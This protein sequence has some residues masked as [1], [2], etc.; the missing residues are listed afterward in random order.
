MRLNRIHF[1]LAA[2]VL[3]GHAQRTARAEV[4]SNWQYY[5]QQRQAEVL[6]R[7]NLE[8]AGLLQIQQEGLSMAA[9]YAAR[10][11]QEAAEHSRQLQV[12]VAQQDQRIA[13]LENQLSE[14]RQAAAEAEEA[15]IEAAREEARRR[16]FAQQWAAAAPARARAA[17]AQKIA[18]EKW[19]ASIKHT[20]NIMIGKNA[21]G[22]RFTVIIDGQRTIFKSATEANA[23]AETAKQRSLAEITSS[24]AKLKHNEQ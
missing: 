12:T 17:A 18:I 11:A 4:P 1:I 3:V 10:K 24:E 20:P 13:T 16:I 9:D 14:Q 2:A 21:D 6:R 23:F 19:R 22:T 7:Q 5:E 8:N 15:R